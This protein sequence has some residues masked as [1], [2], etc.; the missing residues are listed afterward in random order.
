MKSSNRNKLFSFVA[1]TLCASSA[2]ADTLY[3]RGLD[4]FSRNVFGSFSVDETQTPFSIDGTEDV[5]FH[6]SFASRVNFKSTDFPLVTYEP[7]QGSILV[8]PYDDP[9]S[10]P[11][12]VF[13][14]GNN[15]DSTLTAKFRSPA[16]TSDLSGVYAATQNQ[17]PGEADGIKASGRFDAAGFETLLFKISDVSEDPIDLFSKILFRYLC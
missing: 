10:R 1:F 13:V 14:G 11:T 12:N 9:L 7:E 6:N 16:T 4:E 15:D 5:G 17:Y 3:F 2:T 8:G